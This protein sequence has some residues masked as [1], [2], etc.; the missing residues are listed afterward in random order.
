[1]STVTM[2]A[3]ATVPAPQVRR[4]RRWLLLAAL[5]ATAGVVGAYTIATLPGRPDTSTP[6]GFRSA[7]ANAIVDFRAGTETLRARGE[8]ALGGGTAKVIPVY[9][10][11][12]TVTADA[13]E[14]F[15]AIEAPE[16]LRK[17][18]AL[19]TA[20]LADQVN[21]LDEVIALASKGDTPA[22]AQQL[23]KYAALVSTWLTIRQ[24]IDAGAR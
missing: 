8:A 15:G 5:V 17:D 24:K 22:L 1:M 13:A 12:R 2:A 18:Y 16:K 6:A 21:A 7:Y 4:P 23:Q 19:F 10:Q 3:S 20:L 14:R 11:L 9:Q